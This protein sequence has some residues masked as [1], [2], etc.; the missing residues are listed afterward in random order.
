MDKMG[1]GM[2]IGG[3][4][5]IIAGALGIYY[6]LPVV[7]TFVEGGIGIALLLAGIMFAGIGVILVKD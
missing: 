2:L 3:I 1:L 4:I 7:I 5:L 6:F